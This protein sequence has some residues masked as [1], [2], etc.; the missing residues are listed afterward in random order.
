[1]NPQAA[2]GTNDTQR[3]KAWLALA[4]G[5]AAI[6][7]SAIFV[8]WAH[9]PGVA[10]GF[11]RVLFAAALLWLVIG[12]RGTA[13]RNVP[14]GTMLLACLGGVCFAADVGC[15]NVAVLRTGAGSATFLGNNAPLAVGLFAWLFLKRRPAAAF[16]I[17]LAI[18]SAGALLIV[19][20][21]LGQQGGGRTG[22]LLAIAASVSF[23]LYL[24][25]TERLRDSVDTAALIALST[26]ASAVA[27]LVF[28]LG[29]GTSLAVP[30][31]SAAFALLG[32]AVVCQL[33]GYFCL[34]YAL[35]HLPVTV[36]SVVLLAVAPLSALL[37]LIFFAER[38]S[39]LQLTGG[40]LILLAVWFV[41]SRTA[42]AGTRSPRKVEEA[43][44]SPMAEETV[45][46]AGGGQ[47]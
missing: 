15:Y 22:D 1:M 29:S 28:A 21:N 4:A 10:S 40:G 11:Y 13:W 20:R 9:M 24:L 30:T 31:V 18:A 23:A 8:R 3:P 7:W 42:R 36:T 17:A 43:L 2:A 6:S 32:L 27:L 16:W 41:S 19:Y 38:M 34:T 46:G 45:L 44:P 14:R 26:S 35:G 39:G 33:A 37:A 12:L 25:I 5:V 47:G